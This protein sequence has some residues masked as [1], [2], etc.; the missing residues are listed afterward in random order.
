MRERQP[1]GPKL[2]VDVPQCRPNP[3]RPLEARRRERDDLV[4]VTG[5]L[6][7]AAQGPADVVADPE[8]RMGQRRDVEGDPHDGS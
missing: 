4:L 6:D 1:P 5:S 2:D 7:Q 8:R 3:L